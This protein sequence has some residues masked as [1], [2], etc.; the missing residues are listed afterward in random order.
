MQQQCDF[1]LKNNESDTKSRDASRGRRQTAAGG[2]EPLR[3][4]P[5]NC[6]QRCE[7]IVFSVNF[8]K[9]TTFAPERKTGR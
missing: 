8:K 5:D 3:A 2:D 4:T 7:N 1:T 9:L 6:H